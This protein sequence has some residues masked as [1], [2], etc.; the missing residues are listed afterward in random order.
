MSLHLSLILTILFVY[1]YIQFEYV[2]ILVIYYLYIL[3]HNEF[4][5]KGVG[6]APCTVVGA[7]LQINMSNNQA[8]FEACVI[9]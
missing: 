2:L 7:G 6:A 4:F 3:Y 9:P 8:S 1:H 5:N